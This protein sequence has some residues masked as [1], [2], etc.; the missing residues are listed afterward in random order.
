MLLLSPLTLPS[1]I[2]FVDD[3]LLCREPPLAHDDLLLRRQRPASLQ[4]AIRPLPSTNWQDDDPVLQIF[5]RRRNTVHLRIAIASFIINRQVECF[6]RESQRHRMPWT[7]FRR[8]AH[9]WILRPRISSLTL[10]SVSSPNARSRSRMRE[11]LSYGSEGASET[12]ITHR[13]QMPIDSQ[14]AAFERSYA[15][16]SSIYAT[17]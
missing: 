9:R 15:C 14:N 6:L 10:A 13:D 2:S 17:P 11:F 8:L 3:N 5:L 4:S 12:A 16:C 7:R 1:I